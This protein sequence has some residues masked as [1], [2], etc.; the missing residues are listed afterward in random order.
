MFSSAKDKTFSFFL[1]HNFHQTHQVLD[2]FSI[3]ESFEILFATLCYVKNIIHTWLH[4][5]LVIAILSMYLHLWTPKLCTT[6]VALI[7]LMSVGMYIIFTL[8][9]YGSCRMEECH[10]VQ[11]EA[12]P[13]M[14]CQNWEPYVVFEPQV[15][16]WG[17]PSIWKVH[18]QM[19]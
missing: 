5:A 14:L 12:K 3:N 7:H 1:V 4:V 18:S 9:L 10:V 15:L 19:R 6:E 8:D 17:A 13:I 16:I 11:L 2:F